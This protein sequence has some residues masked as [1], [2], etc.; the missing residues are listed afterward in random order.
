MR[1][2]KNQI[3]FYL[4]RTELRII[5]PKGEVSSLALPTNLVDHLEV[6]DPA[7]YSEWL[8]NEIETLALPKHR[9]VILLSESILFY[10]EVAP[11]TT[12]L[13]TQTNAFLALVPWEPNQL[14]SLL[15]STESGTTLYVA[16]QALYLPLIM[17]AKAQEIEIETVIPVP[18]L[19]GLVEP[20]LAEP[21]TIQDS[22]ARE[23]KQIGSFYESSLPKMVPSI[24]E[25]PVPTVGTS[26]RIYLGLGILII[27]VLAIFGVLYS[28]KPLSVETLQTPTPIATPS[29]PPASSQPDSNSET[30]SLALPT[31]SA[32]AVQKGDL[33]VRIFNGSG[34]KG[35]AALVERALQEAGFIEITVGNA[36]RDDLDDTEVTLSPRVS[37]TIQAELLTVLENL[38]DQVGIEV[39]EGSPSADIVIIT[40]KPMGGNPDL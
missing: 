18:A 22:L 17:A 15:I 3:V 11:N 29:S 31:A 38:V 25:K 12:N 24:A 2:T 9:G 21:Q 32:S 23:A 37:K 5:T 8:K 7:G 28:Q 6:L 4:S 26:K 14:Q 16:N 1:F 34:I 35:Q 20:A 27:L 13:D 19:T 40:G 30:P 10:T 36:D 39:A 33:T